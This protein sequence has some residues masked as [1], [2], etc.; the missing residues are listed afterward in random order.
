MMLHHHSVESVLYNMLVLST[1]CA[2]FYLPFYMKSVQRA[3]RDFFV[4][5]KNVFEHPNAS[6]CK[7][8]RFFDWDICVY[9]CMDAVEK[10]YAIWTMCGQTY[11]RR[12]YFKGNMLSLYVCF[13]VVCVRPDSCQSV[14]RSLTCALC[15]YAKCVYFYRIHK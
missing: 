6:L 4:V 15:F 13:C 7:I 8:N 3:L 2:S 14:M 10:T 11:V 9:V 12:V 1:H 5:V